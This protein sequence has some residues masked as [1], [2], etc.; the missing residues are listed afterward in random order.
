[1][2]HGLEEFNLPGNLCEAPIPSCKRCRTC[3]TPNQSSRDGVCKACKDDNREELQERVK[4]NREDEARGISPPKNY[5]FDRANRRNYLLWLASHLRIPPPSEDQQPWYNL[6]YK[7]FISPPI[8]GCKNIGL[9]V[10]RWREGN[11]GLDRS[12][13]L[14]IIDAFQELQWEI[15][16]FS[17]SFNRKK[18]GNSFQEYVLP[19]PGHERVYLDSPLVKISE[20]EICRGFLLELANRLGIPPRTSEWDEM[21][22]KGMTQSRIS[23]LEPP[24]PKRRSF[25]QYGCPEPESLFSALEKYFTDVDF[26]WRPWLVGGS[27]PVGFGIPKEVGE[28][29][30]QEDIKKLLGWIVQRRFKE[31]LGQ[32][33][34]KH[35]YHVGQRTIA[36]WY[37]NI[38]GAH[39]NGSAEKMIKF[40]YPDGPDGGWE[41]ALF[42]SNKERQRAFYY[43]LKSLVSEEEKGLLE[44]E[45]EMEE[46]GPHP[47]AELNNG[48]WVG[49]T[50]KER[51][52]TGRKPVE[53]CPEA[54]I[55]LASRKLVVD[56]LGEDHFDPNLKRSSKRNPDRHMHD[57]LKKQK[58]DLQRW[59]M[60]WKEGYH[61]IAIGPDLSIDMDDLKK[62]GELI[63]LVQGGGPSF[64]KIGFPENLTPPEWMVYFDGR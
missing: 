55:W 44:W 21:T 19:D 63:A 5:W 18:K 27:V 57:F 37:G 16:R 36:E 61:V 28:E 11:P 30:A 4:K 42:G 34:L 50:K 43:E 59:E 39:W 46:L 45:K 17:G 14:V 41:V 2:A 12:Y 29:R 60:C 31:E 62:F 32:H 13:I 23:L 53:I 9:G 64:R 20:E 58:Y 1:M 54:D 22:W 47:L 10:L 25:M 49:G 3:E 26:T 7:K 33:N 56:V 40:A 51:A 48:E 15:W 6:D 24:M 38:R 52:Q 35:L 8:P